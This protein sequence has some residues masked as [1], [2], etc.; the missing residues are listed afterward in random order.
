MKKTGKNPVLNKNRKI[1]STEYFE[2]WTEKIKERD[3]WKERKEK[4]SFLLLVFRPK[5]GENG[6][7]R[8][9]FLPKNKIGFR[10]IEKIGAN[11]EKI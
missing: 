5:F 1:S 7:K 3:F 6:E 2:D 4:K 11:L 9:K 10:K 8:K